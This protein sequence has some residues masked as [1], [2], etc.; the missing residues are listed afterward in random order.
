L[1]HD[2]AGAIS[3]ST[4]EDDVTFSNS[5]SG[6]YNSSSSTSTKKVSYKDGLGT[7]I[8]VSGTYSSSYTNGIATEA[9]TISYADANKLKVT[10]S[11]SNS[12]SYSETEILNP[13]SL[14]A[15]SLSYTGSN[16]EYIVVSWGKM[17]IAVLSAEAS[18]YLSAD[19][20]SLVTSIVYGGLSTGTSADTSTESTEFPITDLIAY[21]NKYAYSGANTI[22]ITSAAGT[23]LS[24]DAGAGNDT[25]TGGAGDDTIIA[26]GGD[27]HAVSK[28]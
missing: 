28:F 1:V 5:S 11:I 23:T 12:S 15:G 3:T 8:T 21:L 18:A 26:G 19:T 17:N 10:G 13:V 6:S 7:V 9:I 20:D 25:V 22:K 16:S 4:K 24:I 14:G 27:T 2:P